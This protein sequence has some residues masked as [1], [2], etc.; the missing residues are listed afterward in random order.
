[1]D[2]RDPRVPVDLEEVT[3]AERQLVELEELLISPGP[4]YCRGVVMASQIVSDGS[5]PLYAPQRK[6]ELRERVAGVIRAL[7]GAL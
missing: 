4:V 2:P 5:G 3:L 1:M 7:R 6:G